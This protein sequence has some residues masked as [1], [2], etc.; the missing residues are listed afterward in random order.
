M[1]YLFGWN[2]GMG[3]AMAINGDVDGETDAIARAW[4]FQRGVVDVY[5]G[6]DE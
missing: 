6:G 4:G 5:D 1:R 3:S 2:L